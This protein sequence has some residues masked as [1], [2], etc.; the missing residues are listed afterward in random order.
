MYKHLLFIILYTAIQNI[1]LLEMNLHHL[2][3]LTTKV[4]VDM[5]YLTVAVVVT[6]T[7][8]LVH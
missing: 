4:I 8:G 3:V 7:L 6:E 5:T 1:L 2:K